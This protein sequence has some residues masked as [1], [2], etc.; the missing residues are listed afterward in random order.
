MDKQKPALQT[1]D[2]SIGYQRSR[3]DDV[4]IADDLNLTLKRGMLVGLLG[5]N[6]AGKSTLL[7]TIAG[8]VSI[9]VFECNLKVDNMNPVTL[10]E[11]ELVHLR[12][13]FVGTVTEVYT[14]L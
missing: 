7:R 1:I 12:I 11:D 4:L 5:P 14:C 3:R 6:G 2:L 9:E 10:G 8:M 13:P